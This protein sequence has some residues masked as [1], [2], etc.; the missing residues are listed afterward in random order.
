VSGPAMNLLAGL[1]PRDDLRRYFIR[2]RCSPQP[3]MR[4]V[5]KS[6]RSYVCWLYEGYEWNRQDVLRDRAHALEWWL[7]DPW[8]PNQQFE[9]DVLADRAG[10]RDA[11]ACDR[12]DELPARRWEE[13][14]AALTFQAATQTGVRP[15]EVG[16]DST[17]TGAVVYRRLRELRAAAHVYWYEGRSSL[18]DLRGACP[19]RTDISPKLRCVVLAEAIVLLGRRPHVEAYLRIDDAPPGIA[20]EAAA[21]LSQFDLP[22]SALALLVR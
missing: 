8:L 17:E 3:G 20:A 9:S 6:S 12:S 1:Y 15:H 18:D 16:P 14:A 4:C 21:V 11:L 10:N 19:V 13:A 5:E 2:Q 7:G 22:R